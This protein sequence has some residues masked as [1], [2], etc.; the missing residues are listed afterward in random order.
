[1]MAAQC[2]APFVAFK[3][4][5]QLGYSNTQQGH[6]SGKYIVNREADLVK[7]EADIVKC[8]ADLVKRDTNLVKCE[9]DLVNRETDTVSGF[10]YAVLHTVF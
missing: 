5:Q 10:S 9:A 2:R 8:E 4:V 7:C 3:S 6:Y 1:M